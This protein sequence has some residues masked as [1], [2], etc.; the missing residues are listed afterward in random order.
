M[1]DKARVIRIIKAAL[2]ED[3]GSGDITTMTMVPKTKSIKGIIIAREECVLAGIQIA[4]WVFS[5]LDYSI[6][7]KPQAFD[8][9]K[10]H[11]EEEIALIEGPARGI[12]T[13]ERTALN[14]MSFL[15][16]I[17]TEVRKYADI[18]GTYGVKVLDTRKTLPLLRYLEKYAVTVGGGYNHRMDLGGMIMVKD[19]HLAV[20][21]KK[22]NVNALRRNVTKNVTIEVEV[23]NLA[24]FRCV[25]E[26]R[27]DIIMLDNMSVDDIRKAVGL[28]NEKNRTVP[29]LEASGGITLDNIEQ[30]AKTGV[31]TISIGAITDSVRGIDF[32]LDII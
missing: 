3:I 2:K 11:P 26:G 12:L 22:I 4:E 31:D 23:D 9:D 24:D 29:V 5:C 10:V 14:F 30:Y 27:P 21:G 20:C 19:N 16:G 18:A 28:R 1:F 15:S 13:G 32:S 17:A 8:G 6:R 7:F 25:L